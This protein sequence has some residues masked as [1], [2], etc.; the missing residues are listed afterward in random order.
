MFG[1]WLLVISRILRLVFMVCDGF[2]AWFVI[3]AWFWVFLS[4]CG[5]RV[6]GFGII[7][8]ML[9]L[10]FDTCGCICDACVWFWVCF[11]F[12]C[13]MRVSWVLLLCVVSWVLMVVVFVCGLAFVCFALVLGFWAGCGF[14]VRVGLV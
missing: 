5:F 4:A 9:F 8:R 3:C 12:W 2:C 13:F 1:V 10:G 11:G 7:L 6:C 14:L